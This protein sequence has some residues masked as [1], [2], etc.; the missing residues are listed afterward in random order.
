MTDK[1]E[2]NQGLRNSAILL[3]TLDQDAAAEVVK[4]LH[5]S[6]QQK[7]SLEMSRLGSNISHDELKKI[8]EEFMRDAEQH[9]AL[10]VQATEHIRAVLT[11]ALGAEKAAQILDDIT[12]DQ[13]S[14]FGIDKLN[15]MEPSIVAE[16]I[17]EEHP[18][19][20][21]TI[22]V[23][24]D[25]M[26]ARNILEM[27]DEKLRNDV[28]VRIARFTG[29]QPA[30][31]QELTESLAKMLDGQNLKRSKMGGVKAAAEIINTMQHLQEESAINA[32]RELDEDLAQ[33]IVDEM[34]VF[35][36][37]LELDARSIQ[38]IIDQIDT[39][40]LAVAL[41]G[42]PP[43]LQDKFISTMSKR[44]AEMFRD[45]MEQRGPMRMSQVEA[46][47]K[48]ILQVVRRLAASGEIVI[49]GGDDQY[50]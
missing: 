5:P 15:L 14:A 19:I 13:Q 32:I 12:E 27:F 22:M 45:D 49:G 40:M 1:V 23:H 16:I 26:Q 48:N 10:N 38:L 33:K 41:K 7:V 6:Y 35:E 36:N 50:V 20:I 4:L 28:V 2:T 37:L 47:Q 30:A 29:V 43:D 39:N 44:A 9:A 3:M 46:E 8:L 24:L 34:F 18:Q 42:A 11:K 31:L 17:R 25:R 21:A